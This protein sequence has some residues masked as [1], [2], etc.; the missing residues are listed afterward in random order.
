MALY[1]EIRIGNLLNEKFNGLIRVT[2]FNYLNCSHDSLHLEPIPL[3]E[4]WLL[5]LGF[6]QER[7][8]MS[9]VVDDHNDI[10]IC[11]EYLSGFYRLYPYTYHIKY[12]HQLQNLFFSLS[13]TEL[14]YKSL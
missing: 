13:G 10:K 7:G 6:I 14:S 11:F 2:V 8:V 1:N 4:S 12:V 5:N 9:Y 3:T